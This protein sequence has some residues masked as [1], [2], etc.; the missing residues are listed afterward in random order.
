MNFLSPLQFLERY[1]RLYELQSDKKIKDAAMDLCL[2]AMT[3]ILFLDFPNS[4]IAGSAL[5]LAL[6]LYSD[7]ESKA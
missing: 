4:V 7:K 5:L 3:K 2:K 6:T 1:L